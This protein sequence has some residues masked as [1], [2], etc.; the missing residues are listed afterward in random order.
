MVSTREFNTRR[1]SWQTAVLIALGFWL[2][3]SV[4]LD[5]LIMPSMYGSG[6]MNQ[7]DFATAGYSIF[8]LFNRV[9][10]LCGALILTGLLAI[11]HKRN[12]FA[13]ITSGLKSRWALFLSLALFSIA[14]IYTYILTPDMSALGLQLDLFTPTTEIPTGM[15]QLHGLYWGLELM[16]LTAGGLLFSVC[17][18]ETISRI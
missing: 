16:K 8:W 5:F 11:R 18:R 9:E 3:G 15:N 12:P 17:Y 2:S 13:V 6:M 10:L 14:L 7:P 4:I 1:P